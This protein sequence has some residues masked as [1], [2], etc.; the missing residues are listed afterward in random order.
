MSL[1]VE[2]EVE[3]LRKV[4]EGLGIPA[5]TIEKMIQRYRKW[6]EYGLLFEPVARMRFS[7]YLRFMDLVKLHFKQ[8]LEELKA[9]PTIEERKR[10]ILEKAGLGITE[11][12]DIPTWGLPPFITC[13]GY[14]DFC[15]HFCYALQRNYLM[16]NAIRKR[17]FNLLAT[18][19]PEFVDWMSE[20]VR[21]L[22][23]EGVR[24]R[25][26]AIRSNV[27]RL[28]DSGNFYTISHLKDMLQKIDIDPKLLKELL[29]VDLDR[30]PE[31]WVFRQW[32]AI[33]ERHPDVIFY[34]Y[35]RTWRDGPV[36][37]SLEQHLLP[38]SNFRLYLT[39]DKPIPESE[40]RF[41]YEQ[42]KKYPKLKLAFTGI[43]PPKG[44]PYVFCPHEVQ[45][46]KGVP[47]DR[48]ISCSQCRICIDA[49]QNVVFPIH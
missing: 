16:P 32:R 49:R 38:L 2:T 25:G 40:K 29:G 33:V 34:T 4:L 27:I 20:Q 39:I 24:V 47:P 43:L 35:T 44:V 11:K 28:H 42:V 22:K 23:E 12:T 8:I 36:F 45:R 7:N 37:K 46:L 48:R 13:P 3:T 21:R 17:I 1:R 26:K 15:M 18:L 5:S 31:D 19:L 6:R 14:D 9:I 10:Y 30:Y 41:A